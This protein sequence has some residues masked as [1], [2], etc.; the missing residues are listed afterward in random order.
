MWKGDPKIL[1]AGGA[2][3][4]AHFLSERRSDTGLAE[5]GRGREEH[6][7]VLPPS[8]ALSPMAAQ[9]ANLLAPPHERRQAP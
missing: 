6:D 7:P 5:T 8:L 3:R 2:R 4:A 1:R 9:Q